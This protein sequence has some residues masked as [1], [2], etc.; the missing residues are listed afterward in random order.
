MEGRVQV[1][2]DGQWGPVC[3]D[4]WHLEE[5]MVTCRQLGFGF[6][7]FVVARGGVFGG[8]YRRMLMSG[9]DCRG[10]ERSLYQCLHHSRVRCS[11]WRKTAGVICTQGR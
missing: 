4:D 8:G 2:K 3:G 11:S 6:A 7:S 5:A 9:V 1:Y 10:D